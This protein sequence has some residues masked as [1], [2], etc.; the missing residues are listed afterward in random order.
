[1]ANINN[2]FQ[3]ADTNRDGYLSEGEFRNFVRN[4]ITGN[5]LNNLG[6]GNGY[7]S[8]GFRSSVYESST[9]GGGGGGFGG[10]LAYNASGIGGAGYGSSSYE[11]STY[12]SSVG[13]L[14]G[15]YGNV[16][17]AGSAGISAADS[18]SASFSSGSQSTNVQQYE[19]DAQGNFKDSNPQIIRRPA[20][21]GPLTYSQNIK[22]RFLQ[23]PAVPPPG[24]SYFYTRAI[25]ICL[26]LILGIDYQRSTATSTTCTT[27]TS[28]SST[29][30]SS[31]S[32]T[33]TY[34]T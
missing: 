6:V 25:L 18:A 20:P 19:T 11:A 34:F 21:D 9:G 12:R 33:S 16:N 31:S 27:S 32:T 28:G 5:D 7:G 26:C 29:S 3:Q 22:V 17:V 30:S 10:N 15:D 4:S 24:V 13:N 14:G 1:M 2:V 23:P 8:S